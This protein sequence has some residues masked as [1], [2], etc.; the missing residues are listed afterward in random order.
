MIVGGLAFFLNGVFIFVLA[1]LLALTCLSLAVPAI[2]LRVKK[3]SAANAYHLLWAVALSPFICAA[4]ILLLLAF[5]N[6]PVSGQSWYSQ[7]L[8]WHHSHVYHVYSWHSVLLLA[9]VLVVFRNIFLLA[10]KTKRSM[11]SVKLVEF[12]GMSTRT[13]NLLDSD[14]PCAFTAGFFKPKSYISKGLANALD[15]GQLTYVIAHEQGHVDNRDPLKKLLF[16]F[17][18]SFHPRYIQMSFFGLMALVIEHLADEAVIRQ[19]GCRAGLA[20]TLLKVDSVFRKHQQ[21]T[22]FNDYMPGML[23]GELEA[24]IRYLLLPA[25]FKGFP[26]L[27]LFVFSFALL[28][29]SLSGVDFSHHLIEKLFSH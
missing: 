14:M 2:C 27:S 25:A 17:F 21:K 26:Y 8:H 6:Y 15:E 5:A 10:Q 9:V 16:S 28:V 4:L 13:D 11:E 22:V 18:L 29:F 1:Y 12:A 24:R 7:F 20:N 3:M 23:N 19:G